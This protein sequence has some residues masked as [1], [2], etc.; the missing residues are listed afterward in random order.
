MWT[1]LFHSF[2]RWQMPTVYQH[3]IYIH[4]CTEIIHTQQPSKDADCQICRIAFWL[5]FLAVYKVVHLNDFFPCFTVLACTNVCCANVT[6]QSKAKPS[7]ATKRI[8]NAA[9]A[10]IICDL[11]LQ[12]LFP[13]INLLDF[14]TLFSRL[15]YCINLFHL[16]LNGVLSLSRSAYVRWYAGADAMPSLAG[17]GNSSR[18]CVLQLNQHHYYCNGMLFVPTKYRMLCV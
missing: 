15:L 8:C 9:A 13:S 17:G 4:E 6:R 1:M 12:R 5:F 2:S 7:Q 14:R 10:A 18:C 16:H 3:V 11:W